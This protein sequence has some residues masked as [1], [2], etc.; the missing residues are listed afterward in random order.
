MMPVAFIPLINETD[1][2]S[3]CNLDLYYLLSIFHFPTGNKAD[4]HKQ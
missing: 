1:D 2:R 4:I 3:M